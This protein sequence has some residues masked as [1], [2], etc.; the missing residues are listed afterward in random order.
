MV[1]AQG[2][3]PDSE[4]KLQEAKGRWS[5]RRTNSDQVAVA[6]AQ[7]GR[8]RGARD[9]EAPDAGG[10]TAGRRRRR[11]GHQAV[12]GNAAHAVLPAQKASAEAEL[13]AA[14]VELDKMTTYA[15][16]DGRVDQF[17]LRVETSSSR[18][19]SPGRPASSFPR[20]RA[21]TGCLPGSIRSRRRCSRSAWSPRRPASAS[22]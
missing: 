17:V 6:A 19:R 20:A 21:K 1:T 10:N 16:V 12:G 11:G 9:R 7:C 2:R 3:H 14:Q 22:R 13:A 8:R 18:R 4:G 5:R 15:G